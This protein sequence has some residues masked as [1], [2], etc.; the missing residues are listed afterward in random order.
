MNAA[1]PTATAP[2]AREAM[3]RDFIEKNQIVERYLLGKL[4]PRGVADFERVVRENPALVE[5]IGLAERVHRAVK[6]IEASGQP[7]L[8]QEKPRQFWEKPGFVAAIGGALLVAAIGAAVLG[9]QLAESQANV[10]KLEAQV[11][12]RPIDPAGS[13]RTLTLVPSRTGMPAAAMFDIGG[14]GAEL[15]EIKTDLSWSGARAFRIG[16][17]R[18]D[19][20]TVA[21]LHNVLKDSNGH[22]RLALNSAALGPGTY[23]MT[24]EGLDWRGAAS[25]AAWAVFDVAPRKPR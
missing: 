23:E 18:A 5:E 17:E 9:S 22:V 20:G 2:A 10:A 8:W 7:E 21:V 25:P 11:A 19:Q 24:I 16:I 4:P 6:L 14:S 3:D 15:V 12:E 13:R 1:A